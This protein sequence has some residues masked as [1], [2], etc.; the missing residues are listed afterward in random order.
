MLDFITEQ[1]I[2]LWSVVISLTL[3]VAAIL[4]IARQRI[5]ANKRLRLKQQRAAD[6]ARA[7]ALE[8]QQRAAEAAEAAAQDEENDEGGLDLADLEDDDEEE[9]E[10]DDVL[11]DIFKNTIVIDPKHQALLD[12]LDAVPIDQLEQQSNQ[13]L[14]RL[15]PK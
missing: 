15:R 8:E 9:E 7:R 6:A 5:A 11:S 3:F 12:E 10:D 13:V 4:L 14:D 1:P 2:I